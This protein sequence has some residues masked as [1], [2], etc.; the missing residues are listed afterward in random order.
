MTDER[1]AKGWPR[2]FADGRGLVGALLSVWEGVEPVGMTGGNLR[3]LFAD[4]LTDAAQLLK[5]PQLGDLAHEWRGI[6]QQWHDLAETALPANQ[7]PFGRMRELTAAIQ[8]SI[9]AEG[10]A[11]ASAVATAAEELWTLRAKADAGPPFDPADMRALFEAMSEH[12]SGIY[13]SERAAVEKLRGAL[14]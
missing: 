11:S 13:E 9:I 4:S 2:V 6:A 1:N 5:R 8:E 10:D 7:D 12:V 3:S 14:I